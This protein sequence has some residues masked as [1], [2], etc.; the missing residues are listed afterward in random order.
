VFDPTLLFPAFKAAGMLHSALRSDA[1]PPVAFDVDFVQPGQLILGEA[2][3]SDQVQVEYETRSAPDLRVGERLVLDG[4]TTYRVR[5]PPLK[6]GDG[7]YSR[8][9]LEQQ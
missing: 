4:A 7:F 5:Q 2:V 1:V 6:Q 9:E 3:L 8:V